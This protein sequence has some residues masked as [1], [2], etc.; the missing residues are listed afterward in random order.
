MLRGLMSLLWTHT[1]H[2]TPAHADNKRDYDIIRRAGD[3]AHGAVVASVAMGTA[4]EPEAQSDGASLSHSPPQSSPSSTSTTLVF[5]FVR[6]LQQAVMTSYCAQ[7]EEGMTD[8]LGGFYRDSTGAVRRDRIE[9]YLK[10]DA[11]GMH[12]DSTSGID[13]AHCAV[14]YCGGGFGGYVLCLWDSSDRRDAFVAHN[15]DAMAVEPYSR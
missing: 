4:P 1:S 6:R 12:C 14:K 3:R 15:P 5:E 9:G 13:T 11:V 8:V 2:D 10:G 7:L